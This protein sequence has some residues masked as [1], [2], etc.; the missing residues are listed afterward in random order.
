MLLVKPGQSYLGATFDRCDACSDVALDAI[1]QSAL[2]VLARAVPDALGQ[3]AGT[4]Q[5]GYRLRLRLEDEQGREIAADELEAEQQ[6][7][8]DR[9]ANDWD[10][11]PLDLE[12]AADE[13][14]DSEPERRAAER[15]LA[16]AS[17]DDFQAMLDRI[18]LEPA[19]PTQV[20]GLIAGR[21]FGLQRLIGRFEVLVSPC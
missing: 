13:A 11:D 15:G 5:L 21:L 10:L 18:V 6:V 8:L 2:Y 7:D 14:G 16:R 9:E 20:S 19:G 12:P 1:A 17:L 3:A 4:I